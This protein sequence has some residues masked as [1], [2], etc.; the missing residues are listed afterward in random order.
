MRL[1]A[2]L[3]GV[4]TPYVQAQVTPVVSQRQFSGETTVIRLAPRF[5]TAIRL[6]EP[7]SSVV[8]GDPAKF[9][10]EHSE[11]ESMLVLIKPVVDEPAESNLLVNTASGKQISF[12]LRSEGRTGK[13]VDFVVNY[14]PSRTFLIEE[15]R[16]GDFEVPGTESLPGA[17]S[18]RMAELQMPAG[19]AE[20]QRNKD[21]LGA[22]LDRQRRAELPVLYGMR[23]PSP[24]KRNDYV[25]AGVSEV[26][27]QGREVL[28]LFSVVNPQN[29]AVEILAPQ[30]Q[31]AGK[32][33]RNR[34]GSSEQ[35]PVKDFR[36]SL[37]RLGP[38]ER[39]DGVV[40]FDRP[41]FKQSNETLLL[42][43]AES[44]AVDQPALAP[45]GFGVSA[46]RKEVSNDGKER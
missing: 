14:R 35:L 7:V 45:I 24:E 28:V 19:S 18:I 10:A 15:S 42:Q 25:M 4:F 20:L 17:A 2:A 3:F 34:W 43:I 1:L 22:L 46:I 39:A 8:V 11:R 26:I 37:R 41:A 27:D 36:L 38:G 40:L 23:P 31:L 12:V 33:K 29:H 6:P 16:V 30:I 21:P 13:A 9:L 5:A 32:I 44:G